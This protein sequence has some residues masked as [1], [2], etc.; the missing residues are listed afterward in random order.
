MTA[1]ETV[2]YTFGLRC[3][4][5]VADHWTRPMGPGVRRPG[6]PKAEVGAGAGSARSPGLD[7]MHYPRRRRVPQAKS[8]SAK[9]PIWI[10]IIGEV[11]EVHVRERQIRH[12]RLNFRWD[13]PK[14]ATDLL[15][16][17]VEVDE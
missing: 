8:E 17:F 4:F 1:E 3:C 2:K 16:Q 14:R 15:I 11:G 10:D 9:D 7:S 6:L 12:D 13:R 5:S